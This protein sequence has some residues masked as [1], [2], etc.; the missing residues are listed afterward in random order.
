MG[1]LTPLEADFI[2]PFATSFVTRNY[3][4]LFIEYYKRGLE[5]F[6]E[7]IPGALAWVTARRRDPYPREFE[8]VS[9]RASDAR[10]F[11]VVVRNYASDRVKLPEQVDPLGKNLKPATIARKDRTLANLIDVDTS[12]VDR[13]DI[14]LGPPNID[15]TKRLEIRVNGRTQYKGQPTIEIDSF[16]EDLRIRGD[17]QQT[18]WLK[19][20]TASRGG[21]R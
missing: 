12:G 21:S 20:S 9:A 10:F 14:W 17:R 3:D 6:P 15:P 2:L 4:A 11:G 13:M 19:F 1:E 5:A 8:A 16:L 7:E 18:Y